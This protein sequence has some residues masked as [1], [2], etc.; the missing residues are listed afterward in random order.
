MRLSAG[1]A[2]VS[3]WLGLVSLLV[4]QQAEPVQAK[5]TLQETA[6]TI[7]INND[8]LN[9]VLSKKQGGVISSLSLDGQDLLGPTDASKNIGQGPY[10]D[11]YCTPQGFYTPGRKAPEFAVF[12]GTDSAGV[13]Y[14]G[15][16]MGETY[17]AT[18][19]RLEFYY[20]L[21]DG[22]ET[23]L[24]NF[25]R[26]TYDNATTP[27]LRNLQEFRTLFRPNTPLWTHVT[28]NERLTAPIPK[29]ET[30]AKQKVV[31]DAT[32]DMDPD[33]TS[34][35]PYV[36]QFAK[37]YTKYTFSDTWQ[38]HD[39][40][41]LFADGTQSRDGRS[42][43]AWL[44][45]N[46]RDTYFNGPKNSDLTADA[47]TVINYNYIVSNHHGNGTPNITTGFRRTFGP[48]YYHFNAAPGGVGSI[49]ALRADA[50]KLASPTWN[51]D[52]YDSIAKH[53]PD[54]VPQA[55]RGSWQGQIKLPKGAR[56]PI[57]V[58]SVAGHDFQDNAVDTKA[59]QYWTRLNVGKDGVTATG[60]IDMVKS[61][62]YRLTVYAEGIFGQHVVDP[63][64]ISARGG[65]ASAPQG[66]GRKR[67]APA[68]TVTKT[69][70]NAES[71]GQELWRIGVPDRSS[72]EY[73]HG[74]QPDP[75]HP[76]HPQQRRIYWGA[77]D[78]PTDFPNGVRFEVGKS[79][80]QRDL[81]YVHWSQFGGKAN[82]VRTQPVVDKVNNWTL[83]F[84]AAQDRLSGRKKATFTVQL[85]AAKTAAGNT[86][87]FNSSE[88]L[89]NLPLVVSVNKHDLEAW[90]IP[91]YQSSSCA[92]RSA[93]S[94]YNLAHK[95]TFDVAL[96][97]PG[98][99]EIVL[100]LPYRGKN[101][102][103]AVLPE[104]VYVQYDAMRLELA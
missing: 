69:V 78:F 79:D 80:P 84:D 11:C 64:Q 28:T 10:L 50:R 44:V 52:F 33:G 66:T 56:N 20:F 17:A 77:Y 12:Q 15:V 73:L 71:N 93:V 49:E 16:R 14:A 31:Q 47:N 39:V 38:D 55:G 37:Y 103:S 98:Q 40:H 9:V 96:L 35:D 26:L 100:S 60:N 88:P 2:A 42:Y 72:G 18:G 27:F 21:R 81:N 30:V 19:Q 59:Y 86:D 36:T 22:Q 102:E 89:A 29:P 34:T 99:N 48:F 63:I 87:T 1:L 83:V 57:A 76:L 41:G 51:A 75:T 97:Q 91:Y 24:H 90:R 8:R 46:T 54:Y 7:A 3:T 62:S 104:Q 58:L 65:A 53:V 68:P 5:L 61:G 85:A 23:G 70:W 82:S 32:W 13:D 95:Y 67:A 6:D 74:D 92:V 43:G 94:C 101:A 25:A 45:M 4:L